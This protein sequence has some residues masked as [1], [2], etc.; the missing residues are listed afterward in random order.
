[1]AT[2]DEK[3]RESSYEA[4]EKIIS[5]NDQIKMFNTSNLAEFVQTGSAEKLDGKEYGSIKANEWKK[6]ANVDLTDKD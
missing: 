6:V 2:R 1:M 5:T 3:R 4:N